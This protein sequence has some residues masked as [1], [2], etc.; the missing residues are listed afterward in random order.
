MCDFTL[1]TRILRTVGKLFHFLGWVFERSWK[2]VDLIDQTSCNNRD[3][4]K[5][6]C[7]VF[8]RLSHVNRL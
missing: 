3:I 5:T 6:I 4:D 1:Q 8:P 2:R 7:Y